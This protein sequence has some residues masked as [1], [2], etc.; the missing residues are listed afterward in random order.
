MQI[1]VVVNDLEDWPL[2]IPGVKV[3]TAK[4]Y[5]THALYNRL[6]HVKVFNFCKSYRYQ[7]LGYYVSL[8]ATARGHKPLPT[9]QTI[10]DLKS[11][12]MVHFVS[13]ELN[14][15]IQETLIDLN[16]ESITLDIYFGKSSIKK[17][18]RLCNQL[19]RQF[20]SPLLRVQFNLINQTWSLQSVLSLS[21]TDISK[22]DYPFIESATIDYFSKKRQ[23]PPKKQNSRYDLAILYD[24][25]EEHAPSNE[26][27]LQKFVKAADSLGLNVEFIQKEDFGRLAEFDA[28]FIRETTNVNHHT[29][30]FA[31]KAAAEGLVVIDSPDCILKCSNKVYLAEMLEH[32]DIPAPKTIIV[33]KD[34]VKQII[35]ELGLPCILKQPDSAFSLG[36]TK[37][38]SDEELVKITK[39]LLARSDLLIAQEFIPTQFDWRIGILDGTPLFACKYYMARR[40]WQIYDKSQ[41]GK[42]YS[43]RSETFA[44]SQ[45]P[46]PVVR[47][48]LKAAN[49]IGQ[50]FYGVDLKETENGCYVIEVNDN[51]SIDSGV[52]D[53]ILQDELYLKIMQTFVK[54]IEES[55]KGI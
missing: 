1:F 52:E 15:L 42:T 29:Y 2:D 11:P 40:H 27:A 49:L 13:D 8:L 23:P 33:H 20:A 34:N 22:T 4:S 44:I 9:V 5:V 28:L 50:G 54:R 48:A 3:I 35:Q 37:V 16:Q 43:G 21:I 12:T 45:A 47:A 32:H 41:T 18:E 53:I 51:P 39:E 36:V 7:S 46:K 25:K 17:Y 10:Q 19:F 26:R 24:P 6:R 55:K 31:R 14:G 30:R 38:N